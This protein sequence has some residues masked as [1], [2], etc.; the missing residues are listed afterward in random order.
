MYVWK[1]IF[2]HNEHTVASVIG[3]YITTRQIRKYILYLKDM[4]SNHSKDDQNQQI[5]NDNE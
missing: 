1:L 4:C 5:E 3:T 2:T